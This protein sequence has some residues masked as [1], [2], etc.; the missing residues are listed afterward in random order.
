MPDCGT[1]ME[2]RTI[3]V[4]GERMKRYDSYQGSLVSW[5]E[6]VPKHWQVLPN[7][8]IF[9]ER[10]DREH[11]EMELLSITQNRG[12]VRQEEL[13][14]KKDSSNEDKSKYKRVSIGDI[15]YNKMRMWQGAVGCSDFDGIVSPAYIV[16]RQNRSLNPKYYQYLFK[17]PA[18]MNY[19]YRN[20]YG[21][22]DDQLSLRY[23]DFKRMYSL[24]PPLDE[25]DAIVVFLDQK[26]AEINRFV[27]NKERLIELLKEQKAAIINRVVTRGVDLNVPMKQSGIDELGEIPVHWKAVKLQRVAESLQTGPFGSQLHQSDYVQGGIPIVNPSHMKDLRIVPDYDCTVSQKDWERLQRHALKMN[28]ILFARRGEMGRCALVTED[29]VGWLCGTG[30]LR[31]RPK[32]DLVN[33]E[34]LILLLSV[35]G[36]GEALSLMSVGSTMENLN[37]EI[38]GNLLIP[39]PPLAEQGELVSYISKAVEQASYS[40]EVTKRE[41]EL[42][43]E[44]RTTLISDVVTGKI[45][46]RIA[47]KEEI[48]V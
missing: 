44:F 27:A 11:P 7:I 18:Y 13:G 2:S 9:C 26:L 37:S 29:Q 31:M 15:A 14:E 46:V 6:Q 22:C 20:S 48:P 19:S 45:D 12:I 36:I 47:V 32:V 3:A 39:L 30:S 38:L 4:G 21:I 42:I 25:Q 8:A 41:I 43:K 10:N 17:S 5:L 24:Y 23:E 28:D 34:Y 16:L 35:K 40:I 1:G 33:P